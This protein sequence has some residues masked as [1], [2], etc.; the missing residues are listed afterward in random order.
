[1]KY[2]LYTGLGLFF[3]GLAFLGVF[4]P[5]LPATQFVLL[6]AWFFSRSSKRFEHWL[7]THKIFGEIINNWKEN[8]SINRKSKIVA[9]LL[10]SI[11]FCSTAYFVFSFKID[12]IF[13]LFGVFL[14]TYII[15]RPKP[16]KK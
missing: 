12:I 11:S 5:G 14:C 1:M 8:K 7:L 4:L 3:V 10:I 2:Y 13:L 15:S 6:S 16:I 9:V